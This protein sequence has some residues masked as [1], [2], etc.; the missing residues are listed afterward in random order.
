MFVETR[1]ELDE[2]LVREKSLVRS[3]ESLLRTTNDYRVESIRNSEKLDNYALIEGNILI[4]S[5]SLKDAKKRIRKLEREIERLR[6]EEA[7]LVMSYPPS[8]SSTVPQSAEGE[9]EDGEVG[10]NDEQVVKPEPTVHSDDDHEEEHGPPLS[11]LSPD[12]EPSMH[13]IDRSAPASRPTPQLPPHSN[14]GFAPRD[15]PNERWVSHV[16]RRNNVHPYQ[17]PGDKSSSRSRQGGGLYRRWGAQKP[18]HAQNQKNSTR[19]ELSY[20]KKER[21]R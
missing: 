3:N 20:G 12:Y 5:I 19:R 10:G 6:K 1:R 13:T 17:R 4:Q 21:K 16:D 2:L 18:D 7:D 8:N 15:A 11:P 9:L 14:V